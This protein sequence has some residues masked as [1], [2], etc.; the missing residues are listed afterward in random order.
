MRIHQEDMC[1]SLGLHLARNY[2]SDGGPGIQRIVELLRE[3]SSS[4]QEDVQSFLD[5]IAFNSLIAGTEEQMPTQRTTH[6]FW[7][8]TELCGSLLFT[9]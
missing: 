3:Q 6:C 4:S 8:R 2:E 9:I 5:A 1:Q 7:A